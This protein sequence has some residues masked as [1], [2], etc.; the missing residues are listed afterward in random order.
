MHETELLLLGLL[1]AVPGLTVLARTLNV[2]YPIVL[3]LAGLPIGFI[4]GVPDVEQLLGPKAPPDDAHAYLRAVVVR[5]GEYFAGV[6]PLALHVM[7]HPS[8]DPGLFARVRPPSASAHLQEGL[9]ERIA[10][11]RAL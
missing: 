1:V 9:A 11:L 6:L 3:V 2:P 8:F 7:T 5:I 10:S 4:P